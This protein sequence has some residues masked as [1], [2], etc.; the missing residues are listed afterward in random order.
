MGNRDKAESIKLFLS[1]N[2][3]EFSTVGFGKKRASG[4]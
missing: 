3:Y 1:N 4:Y 2:S